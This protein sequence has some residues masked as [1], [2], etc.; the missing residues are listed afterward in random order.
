MAIH[1]RPVMRQHPEI[2]WDIF[3][4]IMA[5]LSGYILVPWVL[6]NLA[7]LVWPTMEVIPRFFIEQFIPIGVWAGVFYYFRQKYQVSLLRVLGLEWRDS[8]GTYLKEALWVVGMALGVILV[9]SL[10]SWLLGIPPGNPYEK[11]SPDELE[12]ITFFAIVTAPILEEFIFRG[13]IQSTFY[14]YHPPW[15]AIILTCLIFAAFHPAYFAS[16]LA[17]VYVFSLGL[18]LSWAR[19]RTGSI[20]PCILGH[21]ANNILASIQV[22]YFS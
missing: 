2:P 10:L 19:D 16:P 8:L 15:R 9:L 12:A 3:T 21:L 13:F 4:A 18:I 5:L 22:I 6:V 1:T 14:Q 7:L 20:V 11:M 17:L